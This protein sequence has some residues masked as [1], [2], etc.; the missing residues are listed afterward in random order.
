MPHHQ[1]PLVSILLPCNF[2][3]CSPAGTLRI[4]SCA[5]PAL[6]SLLR[7]ISFTRLTLFDL[8]NRLFPERKA[9]S[10]SFSTLRY[11]VWIQRRPMVSIV[12]TT[13]HAYK[14]FWFSPE[15]DHLMD[16]GKPPR[17]SIRKSASQTDSTSLQSLLTPHFPDPTPPPPVPQ[18]QLPVTTPPRTSRKRKASD[19]GGL[20]MPE[21]QR[22]RLDDTVSGPQTINPQ[23]LTATTT[24]PGGLTH[25]PS[26]YASISMA[27]SSYATWQSSMDRRG[28][29]QGPNPQYYA[30][31]PWVPDSSPGPSR[32]GSVTS[33]ETLPM[34]YN[35][36]MTYGYD[37]SP[38]Y[39]QPTYPSM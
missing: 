39:Q 31:Q 24:A 22:H 38:H 6:S 1:H 23:R 30:P 35:N 18:T 2:R 14:G 11:P 3:F 20:A 25:Y 16:Q 7:N 9:L 36:P 17:P 29:A 12:P 8:H 13:H 28:S 10:Q 33:T 4:S 15:G 26:D 37:P 21:Q 32:T 27:P 19:V 5:I 34:T